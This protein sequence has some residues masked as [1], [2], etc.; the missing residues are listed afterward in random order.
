MMLSTLRLADSTQ[1]FDGWRGTDRGVLPEEVAEHV[2]SF[3]QRLGEAVETLGEEIEQAGR[4][5]AGDLDVQD[6]REVTL[7]KLEGI[8]RSV[9]YVADAA[10]ATPTIS[11][12][13]LPAD[14]HI[15][16]AITVGAP[17]GA[18]PGDQFRFDVLQRR[19]GQVAGG[20]TYALAVF[21]QR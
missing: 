4:R 19:R 17:D 16:A 5:I 2:A 14:G 20:S 1:A 7:R 21:E 3:L 15:T 18:K 10:A 12:I 6:E 13:R 9:V 8:D 11:G